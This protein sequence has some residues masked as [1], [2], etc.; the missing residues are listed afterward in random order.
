M[1]MIPK[2]IHMI[3]IGD[4]KLSKHKKKNIRSYRKLNPDWKVKIWTND[5]LPEIINK[6]TYNK[7]SSWAAKADILRL[8]ILYRYGG[9]YTDMDSRCLKPL[10]YLVNNLTCFSMTGN[11]GNA[12]NGTLGCTKNNKTFK[13]IVFN[14][15]KHTLALEKKY[16]ENKI[17]TINI[18]SI[19]GTKYITPIL[20]KSKK[21]TQIDYGKKKKT[22]KLICTHFEKNL[23][24]CYIYHELDLSWKG[25]K[26]E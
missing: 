13:K 20:R 23:N 6:Y 11:H 9:L 17:K 16:K 2:I 15:D 14:L 22:R 10:Y 19:A 5:N 8:E 7:V 12:A 21:F 18:F 24:Q 3:W 4:K 26:N 25:K 1:I